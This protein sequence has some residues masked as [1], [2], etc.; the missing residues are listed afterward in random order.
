M[1]AVRLQSAWI[2]LLKTQENSNCAQQQSPGLHPF[3]TLKNPS[4][5]F[6]GTNINGR[7]EKSITHH[8]EGLKVKL[9]SLDSGN[10]QPYN[11]KTSRVVV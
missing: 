9:G 11:S 5:Y 6:Q 2:A 1:W 4:H 3:L 10:K 7:K 8:C